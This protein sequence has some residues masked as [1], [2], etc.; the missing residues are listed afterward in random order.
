MHGLMLPSGNDAALCLA[1]Y[2]GG[3]LKKDA[4][5]QEEIIRKEEDERRKL[6]RDTRERLE[7]K[8]DAEEGNQP[9]SG[10]DSI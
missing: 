4:H 1:E 7:Q 5:Q 3:L 10:P 2:F 6:E 9:N 8:K